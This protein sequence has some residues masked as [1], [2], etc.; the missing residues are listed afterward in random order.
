MYIGAD[1]LIDR[2]ENLY[3]SEVNTGVPAG[4]TEY[5]LV[6]HC[7]HRRPSGVFDR[8]EAL[9]Q[10][11]FGCGFA[12]HIQALPWIDDLV[13]LKIWMDGKGPPPRDPHPAHRL[14]DKWIQYSLLSQ[15]F[16]AIST[17]LWDEAGRTQAARLLSRDGRVILKRRLTRGGRGLRLV[18]DA[19]E[20][21]SL[22]LPPRLYLLQPYVDSRIGEY[23]LSLRAAAFAGRFL[24]MFASLA[25][26]QTSNHGIRFFVHPGKALG[27]VPQDFQIRKIVQKAWEADIFYRGDPPDHLYRDIWEERIAEAVLVLPEA[28][29][30]RIQH[31]SAEISGL[32]SRLRFPDL[33]LSYIEEV[34]PD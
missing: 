31:I 9:A 34:A 21:D 18:T 24:C 33:P 16:P 12:D 20:L 30:Q 2:G 17:W 1:F 27:L 13:S 28:L 22:R 10:E 6:F 29:W 25:A 3:L 23:A 14:E 4:A 15:A 19:R 8:I 11:N 26:R 32:Y 5:D 7:R